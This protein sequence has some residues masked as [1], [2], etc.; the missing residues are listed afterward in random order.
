VMLY[1]LLGGLGGLLLRST[2]MVFLFTEGNF[3]FYSFS[4]SF[5]LSVFSYLL[6]RSFL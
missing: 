2:D 3:S 6:S 1:I 5:S 4:F